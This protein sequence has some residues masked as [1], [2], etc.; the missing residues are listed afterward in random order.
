MLV[1]IER[2]KAEEMASEE[3]IIRQLRIE[4]EMEERKRRAEEEGL[5]IKLCD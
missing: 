3:L 1:G 2:K 5:F 4:E